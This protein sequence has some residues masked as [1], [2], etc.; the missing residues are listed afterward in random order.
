[1][2]TPLPPLLRGLPKFVGRRWLL[3]AAANAEAIRERVAE[4]LEHLEAATADAEPHTVPHDPHPYERPTPTERTAGVRAARAAIEDAEESAKEQRRDLA[5]AR[6]LL[7]LVAGLLED[8][9][10]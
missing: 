4:A 7:D 6:A 9:G 2:P 5:E 3:P 8:R 10:E 1:M